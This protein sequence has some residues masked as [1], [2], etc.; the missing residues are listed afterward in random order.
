MSIL[1]AAAIGAGASLAGGIFRN[2]QQSGASTDQRHFAREMWKKQMHASN[3]AHQRQV[4]DLRKAG[5]NPILAA[6]GGGAGTPQPQGY[7]APNFENIGAQAAQAGVQAYSAKSQAALNEG[8]GEMLDQNIKA[9]A[10]T[11]KKDLS[12][13]KINEQQA[14]NLAVFKEKIIA[15]IK[16]IANQGEQTRASAKWL[17]TQTKEKEYTMTGNQAIFDILDNSAIGDTLKNIFPDTSDSVLRTIMKVFKNTVFK[18]IR[19]WR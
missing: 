6:G 9:S 5:L 1:G 18:S 10:A 4:A 16:Q 8:Q 13:V 7:T 12:Q 11:I 19:T 15:E 2:R 14:V 17:Q 3:T